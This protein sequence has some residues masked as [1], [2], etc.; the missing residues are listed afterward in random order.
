M[1]LVVFAVRSAAT[2]FAPVRPVVLLC[3][4][5]LSG[6]LAYGVAALLLARKASLDLLAKLRD[7]LRSQPLPG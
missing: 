3:L 2:G 1:V 5:V 4:E 7:A 6:A